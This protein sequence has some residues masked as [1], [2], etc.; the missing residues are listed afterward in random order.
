MQVAI[1]ARDLDLD[2]AQ[3]AQAHRDRGDVVGDD[4]GVA[5]EHDVRGDFFSVGLK[6]SIQVFGTYLFF[7]F[8]H[9]L[10][11]AM[12]C[13]ALHHGFQGLDVHEKLSL[14]VARPAGENGALWV[15]VGFFDHRLK[16]GC[17][18]QIQ[19]IRWLDVVVAVHQNRRR[20]GPD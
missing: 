2:V 7:A 20:I 14:V 3:T 8:D 16:G 11:I 15:D 19:W 1:G 5:D 9:E 10:D 4:A 18:P 12:E 17:I 13:I 6:E